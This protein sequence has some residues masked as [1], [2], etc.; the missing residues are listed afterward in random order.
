MK[1]DLST[2]GKSSGSRFTPFAAA[3]SGLLVVGA[4]WRATMTLLSRTTQPTA[5]R[6]FLAGAL[7]PV[8]WLLLTLFVGAAFPWV[9]GFVYL[10]ISSLR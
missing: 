9:V 2:R 7:I 3:V 8:K 1:L 5:V 6:K 10:V 4:T